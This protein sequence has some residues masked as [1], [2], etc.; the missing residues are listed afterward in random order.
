MNKDMFLSALRTCLSGLPQ[1]DIDLSLDY[2]SEII[3][4]RIEDGL[5]EEEAV[6]AMGGMD[7]IVSQ[8][9]SETSLS[10]L[11]KEKVRPK[12]RLKAW[13]IVLLILGS[14]VWFPLA[15]AAFVVFLA[16]YIV[17]WAVIVV[18]YACVLGFAAG[19]VGGMACSIIMF[20]TH[21]T[22]GGIF[23]F[24]AS[25]VCGGLA[26]LMFMGSGKATKGIIWLS[27][28]FLLAIKGCFIRKEESK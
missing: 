15:I 5:S 2:Y 19:S 27:K 4:D 9:L 17:L 6:K 16:V 14:P 11:V 28:K 21:R 13:E 8:I 23:I 3:D 22:V 10:K 26:I 25:L 12:R 20:A 1:K 7:E 24:G 18:L